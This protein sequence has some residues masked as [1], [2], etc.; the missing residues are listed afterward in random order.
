[1]SKKQ[2]LSS[3]FLIFLIVIFWDGYLYLDGIP[4]NS[5]TQ[6][7]IFY[8]TLYPILPWGIGFLMGYL[9]SHFFDPKPQL[10]GATLEEILLREAIAARKL[11]QRKQ[12]LPQLFV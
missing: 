4:S 11:S 6:S 5:I 2:V 8:S 7:V 12:P 9:T 1:M 3:C 10:K